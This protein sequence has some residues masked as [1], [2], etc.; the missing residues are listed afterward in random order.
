MLFYFMENERNKEKQI[1]IAW[2]L[3]II[4]IITAVVFWILNKWNLNQTKT[5]KIP[6]EN[7]LRFIQKSINFI[8]KK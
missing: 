5:N 1:I 6:I 4:S 3:T 2:W 8:I 7:T